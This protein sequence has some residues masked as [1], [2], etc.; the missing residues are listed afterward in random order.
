M[1]NVIR[2][3][4]IA[5]ALAGTS[6]GT[7]AAD[8]NILGG[9]FEMWY[10]GNSGMMGSAALV[11]GS[12]GILSDGVADQ[13]AGAASDTFLADFL[14]QQVPTDVFIDSTGNIDV[15]SGNMTAW[16]IEWGGNV[17]NQ[18][19]AAANVV[20]NGNGSLTLSWQ[21][22]VPAVF[23]GFVGHWSV[24]VAPAA[25]VPEAST[26]GM[27]LAGLGLVGFAVRRRKSLI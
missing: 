12:T 7:Q 15:A 25:P 24:T 2:K 20:D 23:P 13:G 19:N 18:G 27:M 5:V 10:P 26:Y 1:K 11:P 14:F 9:T 3:T 21:N 22:V 4:L 17:I 8:W 6:L 16:T